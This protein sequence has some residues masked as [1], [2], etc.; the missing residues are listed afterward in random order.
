[1]ASEHQPQ[2]V[3]STG[4]SD[5]AGISLSP[6]ARPLMGMDH[7]S[8]REFLYRLASARPF[9]NQLPKDN[10]LMLRIM[11]FALA[12]TFGSISQAQT[13]EACFPVAQS[14]SGSVALTLWCQIIDYSGSSPLAA[15]WDTGRVTLQRG[16]TAHT[17]HM[18]YDDWYSA[19]TSSFTLQ[20]FSGSTFSALQPIIVTPSPGSYS[21]DIPLGTFSLA[22]GDRIEIIQNSSIDHPCGLIDNCGLHVTFTFQP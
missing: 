20:F 10:L 8:L 5:A 6:Q 22:A 14:A 11:L 13:Q 12:L 9:A 18:Q 3:D 21:Q 19:M 1:M 2:V 4:F 7:Y 15:S 17:L 16:F